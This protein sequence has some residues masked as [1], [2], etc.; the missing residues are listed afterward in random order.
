MSALFRNAILNNK[1]GFHQIKIICATI[2]KP[3]LYKMNIKY[4]LNEKNQIPL[5]NIDIIYTNNLIF[6]D[7]QYINNWG[8]KTKY[9]F[10]LEEEDDEH[11]DPLQ[12]LC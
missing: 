8:I 7:I 1:I 5:R 9:I 10:L 12:F 2:I 6:K 11:Y 3:K 4:A